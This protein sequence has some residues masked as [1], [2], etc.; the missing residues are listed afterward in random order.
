[1]LTRIFNRLRHLFSAP[2]ELG[3]NFIGF[4]KYRRF[5][6][7]HWREVKTNPEYRML[8]DAV[9]KYIKP[10]YTVLDIGCGDGAYLGNMAE[11]FKNGW[12][13]DAEEAAIELAA[14]KFAEHKITNCQVRNLRID[15]AKAFFAAQPQVFDLVW[16]ADVIE[17]LP[18]PEE[19]LELATQVL[20]AQGKVLI[21]TPLYI[22]DALVSPYHVKEYS[23]A[24]MRD[25]LSPFFQIDAEIVLPQ[26]RQDGRVYAES[27]YLAV[28]SR[29]P[30]A[31]AS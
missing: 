26:T 24:E 29:W 27:Y 28:C 15:Q 13:I 25:I 6:A 14:K 17:H 18:Q 5:G 19:L 21:G 4:D 11:R 20:H 9:A 31:P 23:R 12:G 3:D 30:A 1:M 2:P 8:M 22:T 10:D 7:Y 16:S